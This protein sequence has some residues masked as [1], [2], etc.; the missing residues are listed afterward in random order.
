MRPR[1]GRAPRGQRVVGTAPR[2]HGPNTTLLAAM[3]CD[4]ITAAM[5][6]E[7]AVDRDAFDVFVAEIL[8]PSLIPGQT[9]VWDNLSVHKS[10]VAKRLI[11]GAG[12]QVLFLP[13]YSPDFAPIEQAFSKLKTFLRRTQART[14]AALD[15]AITAGLATITAA[16]ARAWFAHC[17]YHINGQSL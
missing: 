8:V 6:L 12:C 9:V 1:Y 10:A 5:T 13:P 16:D 11:E 14:R 4:G 17:G 3:R 2:N 7:G 15:D